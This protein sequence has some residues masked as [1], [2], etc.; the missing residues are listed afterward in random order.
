MSNNHNAIEN[1]NLPI[2]TRINEILG[3]RKSHI[4][5]IERKMI[6]IRKACELAERVASMK[7]NVFDFEGNLLP[8]SGYSGVFAGNVDALSVL[9]GF[10]VGVFK[11]KAENLLESYQLLHE[12]FSRDFLNIAVIGPARQGKSTFLQSVSG[13][14]NRCIPALDGGH[15]TGAVSTLEND[16]KYE[17]V[18]VHIT[19]KT[20]QDIL[21]E[22]QDYINRIN[23]N[24]YIGNLEQLSR[25]KYD[26][27]T[28]WMNEVHNEANNTKAQEAVDKLF[29]RYIDN[30]SEWSV[31]V[32]QPMRIE[33][34]EDEIMLFVSQ[35]NDEREYLPNG[36]KNS[37]YEKYYRFV[38][39]KGARIIKSYQYNDCGKIKMLD[40]VGLGDTDPHTT[41]NMFRV[42]EQDSDGV[43]L[44]RFPEED[45]MGTNDD[46]DLDLMSEIKKRFYSR[47]MDKWMAFIVNHREGDKDNIISC[48]SYLD[49][50]EKKNY[51]FMM[52][53]I[54]NVSKEN[55]VREEFLVQFLDNLSKNIDEID[56]V[57][58]D[59]TVRAADDFFNIYAFTCSRLAK[60]LKSGGKMGNKDDDVDRF[61][62]L[63]N[64]MID[65]CNKIGKKYAKQKD[66]LSDKLYNACKDISKNINDLLPSIETI[67]KYMTGKKNHPRE[68]YMYF[69]DV[70][71]ADLT[72]RFINIDIVLNEECEEMKMAFCRAFAKYG[73]LEKLVT[74]DENADSSAWFNDFYEF[75][76]EN[77]QPQI[78][79][80]MEFI[81]NFSLSVRNFMMYRVRTAVFMISR[82]NENFGQANFSGGQTSDEEKVAL[83]LK[84]DL[85]SIKDILELK[86]KDFFSIPNEALF[87]TSDEFLDRIARSEGVYKE[88]RRLYLD[89][90]NS[91]KIWMDEI[92]AELA[93]SEAM[94]EWVSISEELQ[95]YNSKDCFALVN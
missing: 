1:E 63:Y 17:N 8:D 5:E 55:E 23:P 91:Y 36:E 38:A 73:M 79:F 53:K 3:K 93:N 76:D 81:N 43:V 32:N 29:E 26:E 41:E 7:A 11:Q 49:K 14:D 86:L 59:E 20:T 48:K 6:A 52:S 84:R 35:H 22:V 83:I 89:D 70:I 2:T 31:Y 25:T 71:R 88:W 75:L 72:Q 90:S 51:P 16:T 77:E 65:E 92:N 15:C 87:A 62:K 37:K 57:F 68:A 27:L 95:E 9:K 64:V 67:K 12:R 47:K 78:R 61:E 19:F 40:T 33:H 30:F 54:I 10:D 58:I 42:I 39:V 34:N 60:I 45:T 85:S 94:G 82:S 50:I 44:F 18:E 4:P 66:S 24:K 46:K 28:E 80:A 74:F 21:A 13:L 69:L 56:K